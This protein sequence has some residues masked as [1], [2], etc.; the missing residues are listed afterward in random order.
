[1]VKALDKENSWKR[2]IGGGG[3]AMLEKVGMG[4]MK[5]RQFEEM[6]FR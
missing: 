6:L 5:K 2:N 3:K 1:M 4:R